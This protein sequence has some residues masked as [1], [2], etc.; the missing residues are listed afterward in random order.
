MALDIIEYDNKNNRIGYLEFTG[1][2]H[3]AIFFETTLWSS[4]LYLRKLKEYYS[5]AYFKGDDIRELLDDLER[6][7]MFIN[8]KYIVDY[9]AL[10]G[11]LKNN[12]VE[13]VAFEGD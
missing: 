4:Y 13:R 12:K 7:K 9:N 11:F 8:K 5:S 6:Y 10:I 2:L 3:D 1:E